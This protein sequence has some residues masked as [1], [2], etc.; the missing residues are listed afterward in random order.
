MNNKWNIIKSNSIK[1]AS[2]FSSSCLLTVVFYY[3]YIEKHNSSENTYQKKVEEKLDKMRTSVIGKRL[4]SIN[5]IVSKSSIKPKVVLIYSGFDCSE[6]LKESFRLVSGLK[7]DDKYDVFV[8]GSE[9]NIGSDKIRFDYDA[10]IWFDGKSDIR[11]SL[12][13]ILSPAFLLLD[14][15]NMVKS[16]FW[17]LPFA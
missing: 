15:D 6:C 9:S 14:S 7:K 4:D 13:Y 11:K 8:I 10:E 17:T 3:L 5:E 16:V 1:I 12:N 2:V